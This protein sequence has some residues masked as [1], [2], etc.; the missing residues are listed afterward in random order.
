[1]FSF[2][3]ELFSFLLGCLL[4]FPRQIVKELNQS[5]DCVQFFRAW[6]DD[7]L[8]QPQQTIAMMRSS[9]GPPGWLTFVRT[10]L[11]PKKLARVRVPARRT[12]L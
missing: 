9:I 11:R 7:S 5:M 12:T 6:L 2:L 4:G 1:M 3:G 8:E 10:F